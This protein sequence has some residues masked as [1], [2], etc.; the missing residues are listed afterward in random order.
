MSAVNAP[1]SEVAKYLD[2]DIA[3]AVAEQR[4]VRVSI[5]GYMASAKL[6]GWAPNGKR[7]RV[8]FGSGQERT[9]DKATITFPSAP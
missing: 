8:R 4:V 9:V 6:I 3:K 2:G 5:N 1:F 7:A